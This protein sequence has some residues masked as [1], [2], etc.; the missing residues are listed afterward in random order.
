[1]LTARGKGL[2]LL[3]LVGLVASLGWGQR[4]LAWVSLLLV[5]LPITAVL[6]VGRSRLHLVCERT[7]D[8]AR[9]TLGS[10]MTASLRVRKQGG[11]P[12]GLL[13]F[14]EHVPQQL[15]RRPRFAIHRFA[16]EWEREI[17]YPLMGLARG[18]Y[19]TGPLLVR[20]LDPFGL[21]RIDRAFRA[22]NEVLVT[23]EVLPLPAMTKAA[24]AGMSGESTPQRIGLV[25]QD[26]VLIREYQHGDDVR[27]VHWRSTARTGQLMVRRE[28]QAWD[29]TATLLLDSRSIAHAGIGRG[30]SLEWAISAVTSIAHHL[31]ASG[32]RVALVDADGVVVHPE[33]QDPVAAREA[34]LLVMTDEKA[35]SRTT[36]EAALEVTN[37][38]RRGEMVIA[39]LGRLTQIDVETLVALRSGRAQGL[40]LVLDVDS[41]ATP[42]A[43]STTYVGGQA[44][45]VRVLREQSWNVVDVPRGM[46]VP[47]AWQAFERSDA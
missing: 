39:V 12:I 42:D 25:G 10:R 23:P 44:E 45:S 16:G 13:R 47:D 8:P 37:R 5:L 29:P 36:L 19:Q 22:T 21:A 15:G 1:M 35:T 43:G 46:S 27:R 30:S 2:L 28:E 14:E 24:S 41:F 38:S 4:D 18:R 9:A 26:D 40:A 7:I 17:T 20:A 31:L 32:F 3:G 6:I 33:F 11:A 34:M